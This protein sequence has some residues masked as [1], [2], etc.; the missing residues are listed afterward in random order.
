M[1]PN[2]VRLAWI[3]LIPLLPAIRKLSP[4]YAAG[5]LRDD[6]GDGVL[7]CLDQCNGVDDA[8]FAPECSGAIPAVSEWGVVILALLLLAGAK[9]YFGRRETLA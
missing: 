1:A 4:I 8:V 2:E 5:A 7:T 9:I 3:M 6:D